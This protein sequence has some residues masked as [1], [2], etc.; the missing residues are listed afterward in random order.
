[1]SFSCRQHARGRTGL[2]GAFEFEID[3]LDLIAG[4]DFLQWTYSA[5]EI[6]FSY[7]SANPADKE[8]RRIVVVRMLAHDIAIAACNSMHAPLPDE[9]FEGAVDL[10][11]SPDRRAFQL[12]QN[13]IGRQRLPRPLQ[14]AQHFMLVGSRDSA[15]RQPKSLF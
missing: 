5:R 12:I 1:M 3:R 7:V 8:N 11:D 6:E 2:A 10:D 4:A 13:A 9:L 15:H 14:N